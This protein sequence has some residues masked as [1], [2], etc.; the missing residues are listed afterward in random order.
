MADDNPVEVPQQP[1]DYIAILK[2]S[3]LTGHAADH[4]PYGKHAKLIFVQ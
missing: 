3:L 2:K 1:L 4:Y